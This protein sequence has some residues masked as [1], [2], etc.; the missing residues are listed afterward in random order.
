MSEL[1]SRP[2]DGSQIEEIN[3]VVNYQEHLR[4]LGRMTFRADLSLYLFTFADNA[5]FFLSL[6]DL[7]PIE[8]PQILA[9]DAQLNSDTVPHISIHESGTVHAR[10]ARKNDPTYVGTADFSIPNLRTLRG[11]H[12]A[13]YQAYSLASLPLFA[14]PPTKTTSR[15]DAIMPIGPDIHNGRLAIHV[16]GAEPSFAAPKKPWIT[17]P[18]QRGGKTLF[19]GVVAYSQDVL[20]GHDGGAGSLAF[21]CWSDSEQ[22]PLKALLINAQTTL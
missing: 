3:F 13:T 20:S 22:D 10:N 4:H 21:A 16:N 15:L 12:V 14:G 8:E 7:A 17:I 2:P 5:Q 6:H 11:Q 19:I 1:N 18:L 9:Y